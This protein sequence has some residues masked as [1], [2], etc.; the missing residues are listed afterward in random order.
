MAFKS[1]FQRRRYKISHELS[2]VMNRIIH[3]PKTNLKV[4]MSSPLMDPSAKLKAAKQSIAP[5]ITKSSAVMVEI[6][7]EARTKMAE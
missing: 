5:T 6:S 4:L 3:K 2:P 7:Q 1:I